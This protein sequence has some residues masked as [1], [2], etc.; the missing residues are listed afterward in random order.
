MDITHDTR[1]R[2]GLVLMMLSG[3]LSALVMAHRDPQAPLT[4]WE[5]HA[6]GIALSAFIIGQALLD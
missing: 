4:P 3:G 2:A 1:I 5:A 6:V